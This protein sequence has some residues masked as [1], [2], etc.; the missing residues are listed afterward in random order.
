VKKKLI[1]GVVALCVFGM[2][3]IPVLLGLVAVLF[4]A[5]AAAAQNPCVSPIG[6][7]MDAGG[8]VR[9]PVVGQFVPTSE[10]GMRYNPGDIGTG[11]YRMH[12]GLDLAEVPAPSAVV[13]VKSGVVKAIPET[14]SSGH[15]VLIDHGAGLETRYLHMASRTVKVGDRVWAGRQIGVEGNEGNSSG[16]HLHLEVSINGTRVN[17]RDWLTKQGVVVPAKGVQG[18]APGVVLVDPGAG[19]VGSTGSPILSWPSPSPAPVSPTGSTRDTQPVV[20]VLPAQIGAYKGEQVVN[21]AYVI[22]AGQGMGLDAWSI[23]V[24][25]MTAMG[26]SSLVNIGYGD[27][28]GPDSRGLF[29]QRDSWSTLAQRM[30]PSAAAGLF[31]AALVKVPGYRAL[32]PTIAAHRTQRNADPYHYAPYWGPA[33]QM[34]AVLTA[35][36]SL[37]AKLPVSG[38]IAG[39]EGGGIGEPLPAGD[40]SGEAIVSA[41]RHYLGTPYSWGGGNINGPSLGIYSSPSLDGTHTVGFDCSGL[42]LFAVYKSTGISLAHSA[43]DQ[44]HDARGQSVPRDWSKMQPGDVVS[45]SEDGSGAPGAPFSAE[46]AAYARHF[47]GVENRHADPE[48]ALTTLLARWSTGEVLHRRERRIAARLAAERTAL[49]A[50]DT[51]GED[52]DGA[53]EAANDAANLDVIDGAGGDLQQRARALNLVPDLV[54][55]DDDEEAEVLADVPGPAGGG[56]RRT[57]EVIP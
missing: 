41:A 15:E 55:G 13:A 52:R 17:P 43:E 23:T 32:E 31:F 53:I 11:Q 22:K 39:C 48:E 46:A 6:S 36:P 38:P 4:G 42:V 56:P 44:G 27:A 33:V 29:E 30:N 37:L 19:G 35:D 18:V 9:L 5:S 28:A 16:P 34:V 54:L 8:P 20:S 12:W 50:W 14:T 47:A 3:A 25:V 21:A 1:V 49:P 10:F 51:A 24:G 57:F 7:V 40:G 26:E 45:F 2:M